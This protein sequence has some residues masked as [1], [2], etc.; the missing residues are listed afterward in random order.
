M[1]TGTSVVSC[2]IFDHDG[3]LLLLRRHQDDWGGGLW[4]T[5]AGSIDPGETPEVAVLREIQEETGLA[6]ER[7]DYLGTHRITMPHGSVDLKSFKAVVH[8]PGPVVIRD[9]E[10][11]A[12]AWFSLDTLLDEADIIWA[13]PSILRDFGL[14][15]DF[16]TDPTLADGS[17]AVLL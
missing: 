11:E 6:L 16:E 4:A 13:T 1:G 14:M 10:H 17:T 3:K 9:D 15:A 5:P 8:H 2:F 7:I 12:F